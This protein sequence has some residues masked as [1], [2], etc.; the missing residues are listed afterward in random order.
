MPFVKLD[1][2]ILHSTLWFERNARELFITALLMAEPC[3][4]TELTKQLKVDA[5]E[6]TGFVIPPGW[7]GFVRA[8]G[9]G[10][11]R[12]AGMEREVGLQALAQLGDPDIE[13]RSSEFEGRRLVRVD[14]GFVI[15]NY[16]KYR[17]RDATTAERSR[18]WRQRQKERSSQHS[19]DVAQRRVAT[20]NDTRRHQAEAEAEAD[21]GKSSGSI[22]C[23]AYGKR[24]GEVLR[25]SP[26][27]SS[28]SSALPGSS[29]QTPEGLSELNYATRLME[30]I[31]MAP[32]R[33]NLLKVAAGIKAEEKNHA[34]L[35][36]A[37]DFV[38]AV[39][40][41]EIERSGNVTAF[42]FK[43]TKWRQRKVE[44][45]AGIL[46]VNGAAMKKKAAKRLSE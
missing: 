40:K 24:G 26:S 37:Y 32:E 23:I 20:A 29:S 17:D 38:L 43:D 4:I 35:A 2:G 9:I 33:D 14:G 25:T 10:I 27:K 36:A 21:D 30:E 19:D 8:A 16:M 1:T 22:S 6:P 31:K 5:I 39:T 45:K 34:S 42:W 7:Y 41:A 3:E 46:N 11:I 28:Q 13:S 15:L 44:K 12:Q 18:R